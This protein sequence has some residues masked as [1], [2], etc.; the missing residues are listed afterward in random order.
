LDTGAMYRALTMR[1]LDEG[2]APK[3]ARALERLARDMRLRFGSRGISVDGRPAGRAIRTR[4]VTRAVSEVSAHPA[5]RRQMVARQREI[6]DAGRV[7]AE[8]RDIGTV[9][10]PDARLKVFLT[11]SPH[12]RARRRLRDLERA[13]EQIELRALEREIARRD[14]LDSTRKTSPLRPAADAVIIATDHK[15]ARDVA[16]EIVALARR[17]GIRPTER[18]GR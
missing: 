13:G 4:R 16:G 3:D 18:S 10:C 11:A 15:S 1:A 9:V 8:G 17:A 12:E 7:V 2:V 6:L 5:V 14:R